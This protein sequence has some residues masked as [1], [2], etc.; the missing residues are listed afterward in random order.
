[1]LFRSELKA[2]DIGQIRGDPKAQSVHAQRALTNAQQRDE[3]ALAAQA[4]RSLGIALDQLG[5]NEKAQTLLRES[6]EDFQR[7]GNPKGE[8]GARTSLAIVLAGQNQPQRAREEY[9]RALAVFQRIGDQNGLAAIYSNMAILLWDHGDRDAAE[10]AAKRVLE[11]RRE[12][13]DIAGQAWVLLVLA[14][15]QLDEIASDATL[16]TYRQAIALDDRVGQRAHHLSALQKYSEALQLRGDLDSARDVCKQAQTEAARSTNPRA[17]IQVE[18]RCAAIAL[19][20]GEMQAFAA[21]AKRAV[22]LARDHGDTEIPAYASLLLARQDMASMDFPAAE[23]RLLPA[24]KF[25]ADGEVV[26]AEAEA[27][28][29]AALCYAALGRTEERDRAA[30]RARELRSSI[31]IR[32][33]A[34]IVDRGLAELLGVSGNREQAVSRLLELADDA[35]KR[36]WVALA[37]EARLAAVHFLEQA[38]DSSTAEQRKRLEAAARQHGFL[39]VLARLTSPAKG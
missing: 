2:A 9:E 11:I 16:D 30:T 15:M 12:T 7:S 1:M 36:Q 20:R 18:F 6:I 38:G 27:Q 10:A 25:F 33:S 23:K 22:D 26:A 17:L 19:D 3:P 32:G 37:L 34:A 14:Q 24:I 35:E 13:A 29:L 4:K 8:G 31:T 28:G 39:W 21:G 5:E